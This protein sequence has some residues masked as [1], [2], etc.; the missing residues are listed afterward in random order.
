[1]YKDPPIV[2]TVL[3]V[4]IKLCNVI[5]CVMSFIK[6]GCSNFFIL[7]DSP[8][9]DT[10]LP[11]THATGIIAV[12]VRSRVH[13]AMPKY[14]PQMTMCFMINKFGVVS[15]AFMDTACVSREGV[16]RPSFL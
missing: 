2:S 10:D 5:E 9:A 15:I 12:S 11:C 3:Y 14:N 6:Y 1:M 4:A 7:F 8:P 16:P 13:S